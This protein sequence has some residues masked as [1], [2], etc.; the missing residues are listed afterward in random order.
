MLWPPSLAG[1][2]YPFE[3]KA[4]QTTLL[5][6][7]STTEYPDHGVRLPK[8][9][10]GLLE[11][12]RVDAHW[13]TQ[14]AGEMTARASLWHG[15]VP[16]LEG[17]RLGVIGHFAASDVEA[18]TAILT[19]ACAELAAAG[20]TLAVGPM[21]RN[22]W[23]SYRFVTEAG[24]APAF[25]LEPSHPLDWPSQ[26][27]MAGFTPL[28]GYHSTVSENAAANEPDP[29]QQAASQRMHDA[30]VRL[31]PLDIAHWNE[32][33]RRIYAVAVVSF[34]DNYL[35][36]PLPEREFLELYDPLRHLLRPEMVLLA[37][38]AAGETVG[39]ALGMPDRLDLTNETLIVK[40]V[41]V[42]PEQAGTGLGRLL[43]GGV[44]AAGTT[45]GF[46]RVIHALMYDGNVSRHL[47]AR[48]GTRLLR[49]YSLFSRR[50]T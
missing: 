13:I 5:F 8:F 19:R 24:D 48:F 50:L 4:V 2:W 37:E 23:H 28:A 29:R 44:Q 34:G 14:T 31:R 32:E 18:G 20:C 36:T 33:L 16:L 9:D 25:F 10:S 43:V 39:F 46:H 12:Q 45:L 11:R 42:R 47:S 26:W 17:E 41:A 27:K 21:D 15:E 6:P 49:R 30:G 35:Y 7:S 22:T 40:T 3:P 1:T 38:N